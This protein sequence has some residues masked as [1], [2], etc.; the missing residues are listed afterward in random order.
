MLVA[1]PGLAAAHAGGALAAV[2][3]FATDTDAWVETSLG[4]LQQ[5]D[6]VR[7]TCHEAITTPEAILT[8][9]YASAGDVLLVT[10]PDPSQARDPGETLY[11]STD[12]GCSWAAP[13]GLT[14]EVVARV[15]AD[16]SDPAVVVA[17][18]ADPAAG[19]TNGIWRSADA[20]ATWMPT[21]VSESDRLWVE[22]QAAPGALWTASFTVAGAVAQVHVST[23]GGEDWTT[24]PLDLSVVPREGSTV[25]DTAAVRVLAA[26]SA[27]E[28][29]V[30]VD[31]FLG[32]TL[33][34]TT[35]GGQ[36]W[37]PVLSVGG[38]LVDAA[39]DE[40]GVLW[41]VEGNRFVYRSDDGFTFA[42]D[43]DAPFASGAGVLGGTV[44]LAHFPEQASGALTSLGPPWQ[45]ALLPSDVAA[46][47]ECAEGTDH[48]RICAPLWPAVQATV[49]G[50]VPAVGDSGTVDGSARERA[51]KSEGCGC[52]SSGSGASAWWLLLASA[53][54]ARPR[55]PSRRR[56]TGR[57]ESAP[58]SRRGR[59]RGPCR[60][61]PPAPPRG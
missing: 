6:T 15:V 11:R 19:A 49:A 53:A 34:H 7:W 23:D 2:D 30:V 35:D 33:L 13:A 28:A 25:D 40:A 10:V 14:G 37:A 29:W 52:E 9:S 5:R 18:T 26:R 24:R 17:V 60:P 59:H 51:G 57:R 32:D 4:L 47:L 31:P 41:V 38:E 55:W 22:V 61:T 36:T 58:Q 43:D 12:G 45:T 1:L 56:T 16:P 46:P 54:C 21:A 20:G 3:V 44:R 8:P 39:L 27:T 48:A 42:R 50:F